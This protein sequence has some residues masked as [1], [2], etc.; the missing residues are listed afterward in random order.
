MKKTESTEKTKRRKRIYQLIAEERQRQI[1][2]WGDDRNLDPFV[3]L[4]VL[5][6]ELGE[7]SQ[8]VLKARSQEDLEKEII[9][10]AAVAVAWLEDLSE[11]PLDGH[12]DR[13]GIIY[14]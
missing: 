14:G 7:A 9:Q 11:F 13:E 10:I 6:E 3:W 8:E 5:S 2:K 1:D 4:A 12:K